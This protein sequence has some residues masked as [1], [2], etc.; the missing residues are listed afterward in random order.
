MGSLEGTRTLL[1]VHDYY[2]E[3]ELWYPRYRL[4]EAGS[5]ATIA[6]PEKGGIYHGKHGYP[7]TADKAIDDVSPGDYDILVLCGGYA[8]D[9]LRRIPRVLETT[10]SMFERGKVVAM[11]CHAGWVPISA[12]VVKGR[13]V[14][15][16]TA[17]RD[18]LVNAGADWVDE[19]VVVDGNLISSRTPDDLP[20]FCRAIIELAS[21]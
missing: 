9:K 19:P 3:L 8:P 5:E 1:F 2:E 15:S 17:I 14:T 13:R 11:I 16:T 20:H 12:G 4:E 6:G 18:D 21:R 7:C 10:R